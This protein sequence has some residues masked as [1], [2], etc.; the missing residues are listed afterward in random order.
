MVI[1]G[2]DIKISRYEEKGLNAVRRWSISEGKI[3]EMATWVNGLWCS[4]ALWLW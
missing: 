2:N 1:K 4:G 3:K